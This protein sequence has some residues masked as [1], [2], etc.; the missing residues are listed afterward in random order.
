MSQHEAPTVPGV[1][2]PASETAVFPAAVTDKYELG[3]VLGSGSF[4]GMAY[5]VVIE[6]GLRSFTVFLCQWCDRARARPRKRLWL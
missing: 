4:S 5:I 3:A 1:R 2:R 6:L